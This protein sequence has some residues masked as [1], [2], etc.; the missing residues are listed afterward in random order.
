[1]SQMIPP[2]ASGMKRMLGGS[3]GTAN[4]K[5]M[6]TSLGSPTAP[7]LD[8]FHGALPAGRVAVHERLEHQS[9]GAASGIGDR[10]DL[11]DREGQRFLAE[12]VLA[13]L[14]RLHRP[15][16]VQVVGKWVVD[17]VDGR[18]FQEGLVR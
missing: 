13:G 17:G 10:A 7:S 8:Q 11:V 12:H 16:C 1:M 15:L 18:V 2:P 4:A 14:E 6:S 9:P 3:V 5:T